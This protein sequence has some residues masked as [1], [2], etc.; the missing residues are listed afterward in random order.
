MRRHADH[1]LGDLRVQDPPPDLLI[2]QKLPGHQGEPREQDGD[3]VGE[4]VVD[5]VAGPDCQ[6]PVI[7][8]GYSAYC[9][10]KNRSLS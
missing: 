7:R 4:A 8:G 3:A 1:V 6:P 2:P 9:Q 5:L 10:R